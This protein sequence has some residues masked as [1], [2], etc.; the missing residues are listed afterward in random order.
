MPFVSPSVC[1][2]GWQARD[3]SLSTP[4]AERHSLSSAMDK[5]G[6]LVMFICNHCPYVIAVAERLVQDV[7]ALQ[8]AGIGA[9]AINSNDVEAYPAD[10]PEK[11]VEFAQRH[12]FPFP[13]LFDESQ[14]V[15]RAYD[16][17]CTPDFFGF[18]SAGALQYRGR[19]DECR[20]GASPGE[21][22]AR[23]PE[24][25][26]AMLQIAESGQGPRDQVASAGCSIKWK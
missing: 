22:A 19:I 8:A 16:A 7:E 21:I 17:R 20:P 25:K 9:V 18:N 1:D 10:A 15:A 6:L 23:T 2:F 26:N 12:R 5:N 14:D 4:A 13:Y 11:M 24:L 3:F